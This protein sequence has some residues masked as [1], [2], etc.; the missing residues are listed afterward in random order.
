MKSD[1]EFIH[2]RLFCNI[3]YP[4]KVKYHWDLQ[5]TFNFILNIDTHKILVL[6]H[7]EYSTKN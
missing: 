4:P 1:S 5:A 2:C 7:I 3:K 6:E